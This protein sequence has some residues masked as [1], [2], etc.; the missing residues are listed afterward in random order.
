MLFWENAHATQW[1][2]MEAFMASNVMIDSTAGQSLATRSQVSAKN[3][4]ID[5]RTHHF[6]ERIENSVAHMTHGNSENQPAE[7]LTKIM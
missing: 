4:H 1:N 6:S 3:K 5:L 2:D 7:L